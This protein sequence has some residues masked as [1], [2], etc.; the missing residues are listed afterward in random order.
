MLNLPPPQQLDIELTALLESLSLQQRIRV[1]PLSST[2]LTWWA[3]QPILT[4]MWRQTMT[5]E[6]APTAPTASDMQMNDAENNY[7]VSIIYVVYL[8]VTMTDLEKP[9]RHYGLLKFLRRASL[10]KG[11]SS[12]SYY[13]A[14]LRTPGISHAFLRPGLG[15][16]LGRGKRASDLMRGVPRVDLHSPRGF[17]RSTLGARGLLGGVQCA[18]AR[19]GTSGLAR[20]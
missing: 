16:G 7:Q 3:Y 15:L 12:Y 18:R 4:C 14:A 17:R 5:N 20:R 10:T 9:V 1:G 19:S 6:P 11:G 8:T 13:A 2:R